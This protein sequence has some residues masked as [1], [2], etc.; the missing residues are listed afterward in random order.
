MDPVGKFRR[1]RGIKRDNK[2]EF[3][4]KAKDR[5]QKAKHDSKGRKINQ[6]VARRRRK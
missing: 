5:R 3:N 2:P 6:A 1:E 4:V